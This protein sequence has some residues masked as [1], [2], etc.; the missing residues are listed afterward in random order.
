M[1]LTCQQDELSRALQVVARGVAQRSSLPILTGI[2]LKAENNRLW[3]RGTDLELAVECVLPASVSAAGSAVVSGKTLTEFVRRL[4]VGQ[5]EM[6]LDDKGANLRLDAAKTSIQLPV[7]PADD[8]PSLPAPSSGVEISLSPGLLRDMVKQ[9]IFATL[10]EDSRPFLSSIL[11]EL[12]DGRLR[13]VA[14]DINR[15]ALRETTIDAQ[16]DLRCLIPVRS[17]REGIGIFSAENDQGISILFGPKQVFLSGNGVTFSSRLMEAEF[18]QYEQVIPT[19]FQSELVVKKEALAAS[20]ERA[21]LV[22]DTVKLTVSGGILYLRG[23]DAALGQTFE[24]LSVEA[25]GEEIQIV[26]APQYLLDFLKAVGSEEVRLSFT[27]PTDRA[28]LRPMD[29]E[30]YQYVV[31]PYQVSF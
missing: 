10:S 31:M 26:F 24:E 30:N 28:L 4:P 20:L 7:M 8:F 19:S 23:D 15:L 1:R 25:T 22:T 14:T 16:G 17:L 9:T 11:W 18:P 3:A 29:G 5:V 6:S 21:S 27:G 13:L 2:L 12:K